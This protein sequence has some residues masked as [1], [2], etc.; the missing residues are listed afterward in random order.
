MA[1]KH[2]EKRT[3]FSAGVRVSMALREV[4]ENCGQALTLSSKI[5]MSHK[6]QGLSVAQRVDRKINIR[7]DIARCDAQTKGSRGRIP[8]NKL[9]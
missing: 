4:K 9:K 1:V 8:S 3:A 7:R 6:N 2:V 5:E